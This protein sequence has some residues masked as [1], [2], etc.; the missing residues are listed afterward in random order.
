LRKQCKGKDG[1]SHPIFL[2][3]RRTERGCALRF[4]AG[5]HRRTGKKRAISTLRRILDGSSLSVRGAELLMEGGGRRR[6][7]ELDLADE[8]IFAKA[9]RARGAEAEGAK[10][11]TGSTC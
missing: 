7:V 10:S 11:A 2:G 4:P 3:G 5:A 9:R 8:G 6:K 1:G